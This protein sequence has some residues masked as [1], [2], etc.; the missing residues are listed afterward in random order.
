[1][2]QRKEFGIR[3]VKLHFSLQLMEDCILP[4]Y[5]ASALRGGMGE[6][7]LRANCIRDRKCEICDFESEC[8]VRRMM[9]SKMEIQ[10]QFMSFGDSVG[11]VTECEDYHETF[12]EGDI[13]RFNLILFGKSIVYFSQYLSALYALGMNGLGKE[14]G[15]FRIVSIT[16]TKGIELLRNGDVL[17]QHYEICRLQDYVDYRNAASKK[18]PPTGEITF[19]TPLALKYRGETL[20]FFEIEPIF[21]T[22]KRRIYILSCFEGIET[23]IMEEDIPPMPDVIS[24]EHY[25]ISVRR[26]SNHQE[27]SINLNGIEGKLV[28]E[29]IPEEMRDILFAGELVHIGKK[30]SFGFGRYKLK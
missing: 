15:R 1:M 14:H 9:Y 28:L 3:Y 8:I 24:E 26:Y 4:K 16:N 22:I 18:N 7:L 6:M 27:R 11:Y 13:F 12:S 17:M 19:K 20:K 29:S 21:E 25:D 10:P 23:D 5:K 2:I 30:T